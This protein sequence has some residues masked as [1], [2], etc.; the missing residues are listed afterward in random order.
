MA[1]ELIRQIREAAEKVF[2]T[3][4]VAL[5]YLH[6]SQATGHATPLSDVDVAVVTV[7]ELQP[8]DRLRL[9]VTLET[10]LAAVLVRDIDV[11]IINRAPL[12]VRGKVVQTGVLLYARDAATRIDFETAVRSA[13]F[14]FLP[15]LQYHRA[16]Y[17]ASQRAGL[18]SEGSSDRRRETRG[19]SAEPR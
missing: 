14:D 7:G 4:P 13:Y 5:A 10:A 6:G 1:N 15:V 16:A 2:G 18:C 17:F 9:E 8:R 12:A 3:H 11:R 19:N